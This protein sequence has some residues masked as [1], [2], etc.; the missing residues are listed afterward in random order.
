[1]NIPRELEGLDRAEL[2]ICLPADWDL[3]DLKDENWYWPLRWLKI[4]ARLPLE[5][6]SWLGWGHTV[7]N[8]EPFAENTL[9]TDM[10]LLNPGLF[11][12]AA[13]ACRLPG[14]E[15]VNFY[16]MVPLYA[17]EAA[18][19][20]SNNAEELLQLFDNKELEYVRLD[21]QNVCEDDD[22]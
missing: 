17:E 22:L 13:S 11:D 2:L 10:L 18:F 21:R 4:L 9:F 3:E 8:G 1:M 15:E 16:Q 7:S 19:K 6:D 14:G 20:R 5:E 12:Q